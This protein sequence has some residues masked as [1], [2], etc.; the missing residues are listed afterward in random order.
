[1]AITRAQQ[2][3]QM[4]ENGGRGISLQEAKDMAPK[5]EFLAYINKKLVLHQNTQQL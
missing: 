4:L 5:G 1:M 3:R 2:Y